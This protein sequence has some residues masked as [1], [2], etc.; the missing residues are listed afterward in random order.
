MGRP[1]GHKLSKETKKKM[2]ETHIRINS[3]S[4]LPYMGGVKQSEEQKRKHSLDMLGEK[5][6]MFRE[7]CNFWKG[8]ESF[9]EYSF[10]WTETLRR[11]IRERDNYTCAVCKKI[12][13]DTAFHVHHI[14]YVKTN[15]NPDNL[16]T[17]CCSCHLRT[18]YNRKYWY[19]FFKK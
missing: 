12:Q 10:N 5:N 3:A 11:S 14:D 17:L 19:S 13:S 9:V 1:K 18:N 7:K 6:P 2:R 8:G 15:C 16:I 4:R